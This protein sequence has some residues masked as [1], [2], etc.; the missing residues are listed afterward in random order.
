MDV[1]IV[2]GT[3]SAWLYGF[4]LIFVG[5]SNELVKASEVDHHHNSKLMQYHMEV[6][7]HVHNWETSAI[8]ILIVMLGKYIESYSKLKTIDKLSSLASLKV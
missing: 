8:L 1:L 2:V 7:S 5:Y 4:I 3:T 6:H